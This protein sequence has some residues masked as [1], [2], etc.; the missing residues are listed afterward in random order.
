MGTWQSYSIQQMHTHACMGTH[1]HMH[2]HTHTHRHTH[3]SAMGRCVV[4]GRVKTRVG[5]NHIYK[6]GVYT[7]FLAG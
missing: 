5:Q 2:I 4:T 1:T 3:M 7:V 6:K